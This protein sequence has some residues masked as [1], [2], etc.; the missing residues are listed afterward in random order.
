MQ[1]SLEERLILRNQYRMLERLD[2]EAK[3][4]CRYAIKVLEG[5]Y[6]YQYFTLEFGEPMSKDE[7]REVMDIL[8]MFRELQVSYEHL[9]DKAGLDAGAISF[10]GFDTLSF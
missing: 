8:E 6:E 4:E 10:R 2:P 9:V 7:C 1:L 3:D 5:G